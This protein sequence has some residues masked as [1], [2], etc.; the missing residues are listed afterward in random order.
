MIYACWRRRIYSISSAIIRLDF[1]HGFLLAD[2][3][4]SQL[5]SEFV[6]RPRAEKY[7]RGLGLTRVRPTDQ[8]AAKG[9]EDEAPRPD[10]A[11]RGMGSRS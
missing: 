7:V 1:R 4:D 8:G 9:M 2:G 3:D 11:E 5:A 10:R 6:T